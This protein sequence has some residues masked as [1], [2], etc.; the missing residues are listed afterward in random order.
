MP[1][2]K[3]YCV[4]IGLKSDSDL[5]RIRQDVPQLIA[6][7]QRFAIKSEQ[8]FRSNDGQLFGY[9]IQTTTP[10]GVIIA[11]IKGSTNFRNGDSIIIFEVGD[12]LDGS[13][14]TRAWTWLQRTATG[15]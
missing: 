11:S 6:W 15:G 10:T 7:L 13:G 3:R 8:V 12:G 2:E 5:A 1:E 14:F 9:F 4:I